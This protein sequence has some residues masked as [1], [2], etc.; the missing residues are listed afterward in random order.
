[1]GAVMSWNAITRIIVHV[2]DESRTI[3]AAPVKLKIRESTCGFVAM[4]WR[5]IRSG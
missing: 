3:M 2:M 5:E 1:M 4:C